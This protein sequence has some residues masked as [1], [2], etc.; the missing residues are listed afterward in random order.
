MRRLLLTLL[1]LLNLAFLPYPALARD[2]VVVSDVAVFYNYGQEATFQARVQPAGDVQ[3]IYLFLQPQGMAARVEKAALNQNGELVYRYDLSKNQLRPF[4]RTVYWFRMTLKNG[5]EFTSPS[6]WFS[7]DDNRFEWQTLKDTSF[8]VFWYGRD[9][10]FGQEVLNTAQAGLKSARRYLP[11]EIPEPPLRVFV[12]SSSADFQQALQIAGE[13]WMVGHASPEVGTILVSIPSGPEAALELERQVPH[14]IAHIL[15]YQLTGGDYSRVPTWFLEGTA[16][17][18]EIYPNPDY[19]RVLADAAKNEALIPMNQL[20]GAFPRE[21]SSAFLA[22][23]QSASFTRYLHSKYG[24]SGLQKLLQRYQ[25]GLSCSEGPRS[26]FNLPFTQL[27]TTW[28]QET[29]GVNHEQIILRNLTP[30][31]VILALLVLIPLLA[32]AMTRRR[33]EPQGT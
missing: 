4:A 7:Y 1:A 6:Y 25:D 8:Q 11:G 27:E 2:Q 18:A 32:V 24:T 14:E 15:Q 22:Y 16:S 20:C 33:I 9:M 17:L 26:A 3:D 29:L 30:F 23:A 10:S 28:Q 13:S 21:A 31:M 19:S 5:Q 12:Y